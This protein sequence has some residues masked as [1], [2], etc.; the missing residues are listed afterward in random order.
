M[1]GSPRNG[2]NPGSRPQPLPATVPGAAASVLR[3]AAHG[4]YPDATGFRVVANRM[5]GTARI[6]SGHGETV[7]RLRP[8]LLMRT[9]AAAGV[10][11]ERAPHQPVSW[12]ASAYQVRRLFRQTTNNRPDMPPLIGQKT[13]IR[14]TLALISRRFPEYSQSRFIRRRCGHPAGPAGASQ[15]LRSWCQRSGRPVNSTGPGQYQGLA[16]HTPSRR[17][18]GHQHVPR[19]AL[20]GLRRDRSPHVTPVQIPRGP[21]TPGR[22]SRRTNAEYPVRHGSHDYR[23]RLGLATDRRV[24]VQ[25]AAATRPR[26][27]IDIRLMDR[28]R[29]RPRCP[30][31]RL[32]RSR[33][34]SGPRLP[35]AR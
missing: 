20:P 4:D 26:T 31:S 19:T 7:S 3:D 10:T 28:R 1:I 18:G 12:K 24:R 21:G 6:A 16:G 2:V 30:L 17:P 33:P 32:G 15:P 8:P 13:R 23:N 5:L 11:S 35:E 14:R 22:Q 34:H 25:V 27:V 9:S 29:E